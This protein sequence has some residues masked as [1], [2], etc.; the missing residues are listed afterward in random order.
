LLL[1][2]DIQLQDYIDS[3]ALF[4][5]L[6]EESLDIT[7]ILI[8]IWGY[9]RT[10]VEEL[11][12]L[13]TF[14]TAR[15]ILRAYTDLLNIIDYRA[16]GVTKPIVEPINLSDQSVEYSMIMVRKILETMQYTDSL[17][18]QWFVKIIVSDPLYFED[19]FREPIALVW[20]G[21]KLYLKKVTVELVARARR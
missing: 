9:A 4:Y 1:L 8:R 3:S 7:S 6:A 12:I 16:M 19:V 13:D 20:S 2:Q 5:R 21:I 14:Q 11:T 15:D 18:T 17:F 10:N